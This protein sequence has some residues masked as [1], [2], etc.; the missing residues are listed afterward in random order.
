MGRKKKKTLKK[1]RGPKGL[2]T[3]YLSIFSYLNVEDI[4]TTFRQKIYQNKYINKINQK[5]LNIIIYFELILF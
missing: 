3:V 1:K 2:F 4:N 5:S